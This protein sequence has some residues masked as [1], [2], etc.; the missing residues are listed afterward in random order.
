MTQAAEIQLGYGTVPGTPVSGKVSLHSLTGGE[1]Q[2]KND[3]AVVLPLA[4]YRIATTT[5]IASG[6][7][8]FSTI[9]QTYKHLLLIGSI[10]SAN[11]GTDEAGTMTVNGAVSADYYGIR[12]IFQTVGYSGTGISAA[13]NFLLGSVT[14]ATGGGTRVPLRIEFPNYTLASIPNWQGEMAY[15]GG[16]IAASQGKYS[17]QGWLNIAAAITT[18]AVSC[19]SGFNIGSTLSL[20][21]VY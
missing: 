5:L 2:L 20:Y 6:S 4:M 11:A 3:A 17:F 7:F 9:P 14:A 16:T 21:G 19:A 12:S 15:S 1:L 10:R 13:S 8:T 18:I